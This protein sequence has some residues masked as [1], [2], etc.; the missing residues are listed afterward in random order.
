MAQLEFDAHTFSSLD[1]KSML[2]PCRHHIKRFA[3]TM[4]EVVP[5]RPSYPQHTIIKNTYK[6]VSDYF[7]PFFIT[8]ILKKCGHTLGHCTN[9]TAS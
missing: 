1:F 6:R 9:I 7:I 2:P 5:L 8:Y 4:A 3:D